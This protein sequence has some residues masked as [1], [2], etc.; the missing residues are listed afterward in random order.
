MSRKYTGQNLKK[1]SH[2]DS[3]DCSMPL[4]PLL[5]PSLSLPLNSKLVLTCSTSFFSILSLITAELVSINSSSTLY[6]LNEPPEELECNPYNNRTDPPSLS[7]P[8]LCTAVAGVNSDSSTLWHIAWHREDSDGNIISFTKH[9]F[10][11]NVLGVALLNDASATN[12]SVNDSLWGNYYCIVSS[13]LSNENETMILR[14]KTL[15]L[16]P[17]EN[18][19][20]LVACSPVITDDKKNCQ[21]EESTVFFSS[22]SPTST[23][24]A[25]IVISSSPSVSSPSNVTSPTSVVGWI[26]GIAFTSVLVIILSI[27]VLVLLLMYKNHYEIK[28]IKGKCQVYMHRALFTNNAQITNSNF[29]NLHTHNGWDYP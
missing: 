26:V 11:N 20:S 18:Y 5:P 23:L 4:P 6:Y 12:S 21:S 9:P 3:K 14:S 13:S 27:I 16:L 15:Q 2:E 22:S 10:I 7:T 17:P 29:M 24:I 19:S 28:P 1:Q 25:S 8:F